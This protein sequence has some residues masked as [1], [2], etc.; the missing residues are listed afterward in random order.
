M[1]TDPIADM[2]TRIRNGNRN[3]APAV[4]MPHTNVKQNIAQVLKDEGFILDF[5]VGSMVE[6]DGRPVFH[7]GETNTPKKILRVFLRYGPDGERVIRNIER[8]SSPGC[9]IYRGSR[10]LRPVLQGL[11]ISILSTNKGVMSD[12]QAR[13]QRVGGELLCRVW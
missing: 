13:A 12:R 4:D 1:M 2:L 6:E 11:G 10:E 7:P 3:E 5:Q 8:S 9:R